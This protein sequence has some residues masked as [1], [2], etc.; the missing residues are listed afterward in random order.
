MT[1][2][3]L[4]AEV[5]RSKGA[6]DEEIE[7]RGRFASSYLPDA[8]VDQEIPPEAV[9]SLRAHLLRLFDECQQHPEKHLEFLERRT[10][11]ISARN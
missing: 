9:E 6:S 4:C 3:Q 2:R 5:M 7:E 11:Q 1:M 10:A 8:P